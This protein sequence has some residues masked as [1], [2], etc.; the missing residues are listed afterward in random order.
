MEHAAITRFQ[1]IVRDYYASHGRHDLPWRLPEDDGSFDPYK[2]WV[3]E[4]MLQQTQV[5]RCIPIYRKLIYRYPTVFDLAAAPLSDVLVAW[6]GLGYNRRAKY[7]HQAAQM[8]VQDFGGTF[9][10]DPLQLTKLPGVG[11]N[12]AAAIAAYAFN[13]PVVFVETNIRTVFIHHFFKD[14]TGIPD[15]AILELVGQTLDRQN[16]RIWYWALM[17]YGSFLKKSVGNLNT[18]S[19][20]Y[21]KQS[22]FQGSRRQ[23]RGQVLRLLAGGPQPSA[24]LKRQIPD[25]RL[26]VVLAELTA[27]GFIGREG[28]T[29]QLGA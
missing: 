3:S 20:H 18:L 4:I 26:D 7:L 15:T 13:E 21:T 16:P 6:N 1:K 12:T 25:E 9:P 27:E 8:V 11:K 10:H 2:I 19:K 24:K 23:I 17:D 14:D 29:Y 5:I 22:P 28:S